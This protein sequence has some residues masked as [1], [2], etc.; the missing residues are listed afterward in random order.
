MPNS[1]MSWAFLFCNYV[2]NF[3]MHKSTIHKKPMYICIVKKNKYDIL[4]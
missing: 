2:H 3:L 4:I 1:E